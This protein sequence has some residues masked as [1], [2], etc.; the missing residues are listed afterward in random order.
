MQNENHGDHRE[1]EK[2]KAL[3][4]TLLD[5]AMAC[6]NCAAACLTESH[7]GMNKCVSMDIDCAD[8]C[9]L[10]AKLL[11]RNSAIAHEFL[12]ICEKACRMCAEECSKHDHEHCKKCAAACNE[13]A[14]AC[15]KHHGATALN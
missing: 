3:I 1:N 13:C 8:I 9:F 12:L 5:C 15:H 7:S 14:E 6:E 10:A 4:K 2:H 11:E